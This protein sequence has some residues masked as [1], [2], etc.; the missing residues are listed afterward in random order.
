MA[1]RIST[2]TRWAIALPGVLLVLAVGGCPKAPSSGFRPV[3]PGASVPVTL[4]ANQV[5]TFL[6][7]GREV[8]AGRRVQLLLEDAPHRIEARAPGYRAKEE[9][10]YPPYGDDYYLRFT[11]Q[12]SDRLDEA[13][14]AGRG[15]VIEV[16]ITGLSDPRRDG[17][18]RDREEAILNAKLQAIER[19]GVSIQSVTEL[20]NFVLKRDRVEQT[21]GGVLLPGHRIQD[22]GYGADGV[23]RVVLVGE[24]RRTP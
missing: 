20:E 23:Y 6:V 22:L 13:G 21:A 24:V 19:A 8:G 4:Y 16:V 11:F 5:T 9:H 14:T 18:Q 12:V 17:P 15:G 1:R 7:D 10:V 2:A 3:G